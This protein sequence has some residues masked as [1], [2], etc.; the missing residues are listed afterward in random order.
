MRR[1]LVGLIA[2][3]SVFFPDIGI[4][5]RNDGSQPVAFA[6]GPFDLKSREVR[7]RV[8][9]AKSLKAGNP[10]HVR[11]LVEHLGKE[12][13]G[14]VMRILIDAAIRLKSRET[15]LPVWR[16]MSASQYALDNN[17]PGV[18][19]ELK[20]REKAKYVTVLKK[21]TKY[22]EVAAPEILPTIGTA[23]GDGK[24][25][26][27]VFQLAVS[28]PDNLKKDAAT[29]VERLVQVRVK[30]E[31]IEVYPVL[32][33]LKRHTNSR[34]D[35][36]AIVNL[37]IKEIGPLPP[38]TPGWLRDR[39]TLR[40]LSNGDII[41]IKGARGA[42]VTLAGEILQIID[43]KTLILLTAAAKNNTIWA[44]GFPTKGFADEDD[45]QLT[46]VLA[47]THA[48]TTVKG[49]KRTIRRVIPAGALRLPPLS[50][51]DYKRT[52]ASLKSRS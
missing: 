36:L 49:A 38:E 20:R 13:N 44:E 40:K 31:G 37:G 1:L 5:L 48:Y 12:K 39:K 52:S 42:P 24:F 47:G 32:I 35:L 17:L 34:P 43:S 26:E 29:A 14:Y 8:R 41:S 22:M 45:V 11:A 23:A 46:V 10:A 25:L 15:L 16:V 4:V 7:T 30:D 27:A 19:S 2:V 3:F 6:D 21:C 51:A 18:R 33:N 28:A 50:F 9:G